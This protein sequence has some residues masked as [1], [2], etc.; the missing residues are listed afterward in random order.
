MREGR[1]ADQ[2]QATAIGSHLRARDLVSRDLGYFSLEALEQ[3]TRKEAWFL[4]RLSSAVAV[5]TTADATAPAVAVVDHVQP[6]VAQHG[7]QALMVY[8]GER[9]LPCRVLAYHLPQEVVEQRRRH[10]HERARKKG[11][12]PTQ[13]YLHWLQYGWY[14]TNV[15]TT[16]WAAEIVATVYRIRWQIELVFKQWQSLLHLHVLKGTCPE[17]I[18]CLL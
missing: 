5:S 17:R 15:G 11:R 10:A 1:A 18:Q 3:M 9:R 2:G 6:M 7:V 4:S 12:T 16:I 14:T 13:A 8:L